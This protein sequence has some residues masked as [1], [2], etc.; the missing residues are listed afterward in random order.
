LKKDHDHRGR[1]GRGGRE[2]SRGVKL[3]NGPA[4][5]EKKQG[6]EDGEKER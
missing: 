1:E 3:P 6:G 2:K 5:I 4:E